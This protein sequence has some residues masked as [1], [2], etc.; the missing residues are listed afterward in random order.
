MMLLLVG[1]DPITNTPC[2]L[3]PLQRKVPE[4]LGLKL[5]GY[6]PFSTPEDGVP[7]DQLGGDYWRGW[8]CGKCGMANERRR[9]SGWDCDGCKVCSSLS[10]L[11]LRSMKASFFLK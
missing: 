10:L 7:R 5:R 4:F 8:V 9:W 6:D 11:C 1:L 2:L 3:R